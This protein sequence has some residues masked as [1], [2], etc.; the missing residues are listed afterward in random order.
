MLA[1]V[2]LDDEA[3]RVEAAH[4]VRTPMERLQ[5][6]SPSARTFTLRRCVSGYVVNLML[7]SEPDT[8]SRILGGKFQRDEG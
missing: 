8:G 7:R 3:G 6:A 5:R 4:W 1:V 2:G